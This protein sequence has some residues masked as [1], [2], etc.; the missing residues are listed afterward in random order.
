MTSHFRFRLYFLAHGLDT[1]FWNARP[2][3]C[4][5]MLLLSFWVF[6]HMYPKLSPTR[7]IL[8]YSNDAR[9]IHKTAYILGILGNVPNVQVQ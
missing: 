1:C 3:P 2:I 7:K 9:D 4:Y 6:K 5:A 8:V